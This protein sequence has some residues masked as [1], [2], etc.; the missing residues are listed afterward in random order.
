MPVGSVQQ[1]QHDVSGIGWAI[2]NADWN[3]R[4]TP[5]AW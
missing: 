3:K 2:S 1:L 4:V 5:G